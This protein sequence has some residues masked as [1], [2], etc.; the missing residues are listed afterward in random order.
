MVYP[1]QCVFAGTTNHDIYLP[2]ETGGRRFWPVKIG[3]VDL[4]GLRRDR[5]QLWAE[6]VHFYRNGEPWHLQD[7]A[8]IATATDEQAGDAKS[9]HG[10][11]R[12]PNTWRIGFR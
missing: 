7:D 1:R 11:S 8:V 3:I 9:M 2:D 5:D 12:S 4:D 6:A 10:K